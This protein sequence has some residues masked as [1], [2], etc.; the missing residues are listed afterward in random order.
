MSLIGT[1]TGV[2]NGAA[3]G[4]PLSGVAGGAADSLAGVGLRA[5]SS[6]VLDGTKSALEAVARIIGNATSPNL[7]STWFSATYWRVAALAAALTMPFLFAAAIQALL[8][9][10]LAL[11]TRAVFGYLPLSLI[12]VSI[13]APV[14]MLLLAATDQMSAVVSA[15]GTEG[16]ARFLDQAAAAT[17][18]S[19]VIDGSPF[20]AVVIGVC[21]VMAALTLALELLVREAA[22]YVVVLM[23]PLAFA[24]M[25]W[26]A[27]RIWAVRLAEL[28][29]SLI[30]SKFV[31]V[32][33]LSLAGAAFSNG[34]PGV[35]ELLVAMALV[36][37]SV[38]APWTLIRILPFTE[39]AASA[40]GSM[41]RELPSTADPAHH[42]GAAMGLGDAAAMLPGRLRQQL[43]QQ[44][45]D[46]DSGGFS[47]VTAPPS[48][49]DASQDARSEPQNQT[50]AAGDRA[51]SPDS[52]HSADQVATPARSTSPSPDQ[53]GSSPTTGTATSVRQMPTPT[54][55]ADGRPPLSRPWTTGA[56][57]TPLVIGLDF[58]NNGFGG[59]PPG[60]SSP[61]STGGD[62][63]EGLPAM[64]TGDLPD[65]RPDTGGSR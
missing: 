64:D 7:T 37:L 34:R 15:A 25:V 60:D 13:A 56:V 4:S 19:S 62:A 58:V 36:L 46:T 61:A 31:I 23:L 53:E 57:E 11:L 52:D 50:M 48:T 9:S 30:I 22:V 41:R 12:G 59:G 20:F 10:D 18:A 47:S 51:E 14:T 3:N 5:I 16:G 6:W 49:S 42:L 54:R 40:A 29:V 27:R 45:A 35:S 2:L 38:F 63:P 55:H 26:P 43:R 8:R 33:V 44:G 21:A 39:L 1:F 28:L 24:A 32:A 65:H 17:G